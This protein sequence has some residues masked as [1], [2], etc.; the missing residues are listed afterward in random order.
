MLTISKW[1]GL[2]DQSDLIADTDPETIK[3][4]ER[5]RAEEKAK[6]AQ[7]DNEKEQEGGDKKE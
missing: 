5:K 7:E 2:N 1:T 3:N 4:Y 6:K